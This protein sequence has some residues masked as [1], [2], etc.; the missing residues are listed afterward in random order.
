M[1]NDPVDHPEHYTSHPSGIEAIEILQHFSFP[2]GSAIKYLWRADLK[3]APVQD[4]KKARWF[5]DHEIRRR[6]GLVASQLPI[7]RQ[8]QSYRPIAPPTKPS[9]PG[10]VDSRSARSQQQ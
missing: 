10:Q 9:L 2:I 1:S 8:Q 4:L 5:L 6:E 7:P 3:G